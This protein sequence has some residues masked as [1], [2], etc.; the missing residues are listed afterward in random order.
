MPYE[1][2]HRPPI[3]QLAGE[4]FGELFEARPSPRQPLLVSVHDE[5]A[6]VMFGVYA[7]RD[8]RRL[9]RFDP[10]SERVLIG[11]AFRSGKLI[12]SRMFSRSNGAP[13][14]G[15][16]AR[17]YHIGQADFDPATRN[18]E[19][20]QVAF[21]SRALYNRA[22]LG[23]MVL[24]LNDLRDPAVLNPRLHAEAHEHLALVCGFGR[25]FFDD[26]LQRAAELIVA[27]PPSSAV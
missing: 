24:A 20:D 4:L 6:R 9:A 17:S 18:W 16:T 14:R 13:L 1:S 5:H 12:V 19:E 25:Q 27:T 10:G 2:S 8:G 22:G 7:Y 15:P 21:R 26:H 3:E 11:A 23:E